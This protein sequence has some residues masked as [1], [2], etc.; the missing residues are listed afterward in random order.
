LSAPRQQHHPVPFERE[1]YH[2]LD[3]LHLAITFKVFED[4]HAKSIRAAVGGASLILLVVLP[5]LPEHDP[6]A[7]R[8]ILCRLKHD[9]LL[10]LF[11]RRLRV[12]FKDFF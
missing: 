6:S 8:E 1:K 3:E 5:A 7:A 2:V 4:V 11:V 10:N 9:I 12:L